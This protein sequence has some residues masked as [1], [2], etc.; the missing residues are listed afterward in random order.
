MLKPTNTH[1][2]WELSLRDRDMMPCIGYGSAG[3]GKTY[4][5]VG[6]AVEWLEKG[7]KQKVIVT[8]P[9]VSFADD[10]GFLPGTEREKLDPWVRPIQQNLA[11]HGI[12]KAHQEDLEKRGKIAYQT[13]AF[14]QGL[15]FDNSFIIV[16]ECQNLTFDQIKAV[17][18]RV[19][20]WSKLVL[21]G[22]IAQTSPHFK[23]SGL[24]EWIEMT[25]KL[26]LPFHTIEF[27]QDDI[28]RGNV[29]KQTIIACEKWEEM[30]YGYDKR[31]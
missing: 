2:L 5:A 4:G 22:D 9:N 10:V 8:R 15:T 27:T 25:K 1:K 13:F 24:A 28:L 3:T 16:D 31:I 6:A 17:F 18:T 26:N 23:G 21:C 7:N 11:A 29:C 19:G 30:Q 20:N 12:G 14:I